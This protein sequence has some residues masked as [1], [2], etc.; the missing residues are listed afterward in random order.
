M[1]SG[2]YDMRGFNTVAKMKKFYT[3][4]IF[5]SHTVNVQKK[6]DSDGKGGMRWRHINTASSIGDVMNL[7][8]VGIH[9]VCI[10]RKVQHSTG[11]TEG[12]VGFVTNDWDFLYCFMSLQNLEKL[13]V[14]YR[15]KPLD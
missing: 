10:N 2:F 6:H 11:D 7:I 3:D 9:N 8:K 13:I 5:L 15:L 14:K 4:A 1:V 12:E